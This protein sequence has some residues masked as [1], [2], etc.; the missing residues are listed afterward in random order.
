MEYDESGIQLRLLS[1][2]PDQGTNF[3]MSKDLLYSIRKRLMD[4]GISVQYPRREVV[5]KDVPPGFFGG[6]A[7]P[8]P[9][10]RGSAK[11]P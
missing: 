9:A 6:D 1:N 3:Q 7:G 2:A 11:K 5:F 4:E 10:K 8:Q